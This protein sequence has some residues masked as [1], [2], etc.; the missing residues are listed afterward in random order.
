M[1]VLRIVLELDYPIAA[2]VIRDRPRTIDRDADGVAK[3]GLVDQPGG[4][5]TNI[6]RVVERAYR[7]EFDTDREEIVCK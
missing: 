5:L 2:D 7:L 4:L 6:D 3:T 1:I